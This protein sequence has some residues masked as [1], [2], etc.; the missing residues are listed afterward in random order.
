MRRFGLP[1]ASLVASL[2]C[3]GSAGGQ[4]GS[5]ACATGV[6]ARRAIEA[7]SAA[8]RAD[9][10]NALLYNRRGDVFTAAGAY[11]RALADYTEAVRLNPQYALAFRNR[12][13][14]HF[15]RADF[16]AAAADFAAAEAIDRGNAY[17][18]LWRYVAEARAGTVDRAGLHRAV[19]GL[20]EGW[21]KPLVL[22]YLG[23]LGAEAVLAEAQAEP[24]KAAERLCEAHF[25]LGQERLLAGDAAAAVAALRQA[26]AVCPGNMVEHQATRVE[27]NRLG[28]RAP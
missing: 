28:A 6:D 26:G 10:G 16:A 19:A 5:A 18:L 23:R 27:L 22:Y 20:R 11:A 24:A 9:L 21:P 14:V 1:I 2:A 25:F 17:A 4:A 8:I 13:R 15:Y 3:A 7:C 12:A